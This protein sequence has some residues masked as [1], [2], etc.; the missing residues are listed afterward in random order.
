MEGDTYLRISKPQNRE[1]EHGGRE[2]EG[3]RATAN[4]D[5]A[6]QRLEEQ[7]QSGHVTVRPLCPAFST[8]AAEYSYGGVRNTTL[9]GHRPSPFQRPGS[10]FK[11]QQVPASPGKTSSS[12]SSPYPSPPACSVRLRVSIVIE[13]RKLRV[14]V[15]TYLSWMTSLQTTAV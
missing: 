3:G 12:I 8:D 10:I 9:A 5:S 14:F 2:R 7:R 4:P 15:R 1:L 13:A 6:P 11:S